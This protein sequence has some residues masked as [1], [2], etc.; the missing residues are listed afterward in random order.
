MDLLNLSS[1]SPS[2][3]H[4]KVNVAES[5]ADFL[6]IDDVA[7]NSRRQIE[8]NLIDISI[9]NNFGD[10]RVEHSGTERPKESSNVTS[11]IDDGDVTAAVSTTAPNTFDLLGDLSS[12]FTTQPI[13]IKTEKKNNTFVDP[14]D[15]QSNLTRVINLSTAILLVKT[16]RIS[17]NI[18][19]NVFVFYL[20]F[21]A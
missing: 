4:T 5:T 7:R 6:N 8:E 14:F 19:Y 15:F 3:N 21:Y 17:L 18:T 9:A 10:E 2:S 20:L 1:S 12:T 13:E 16:V 11:L